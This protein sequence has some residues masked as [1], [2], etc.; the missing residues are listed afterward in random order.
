MVHP[1][2]ELILR[3]ASARFAEN[4]LHAT[5]MRDIASS[6]DLHLPSIY[7]FFANKEAL[8]GRCV[9]LA[10]QRT[11]EQLD[12]HLGPWPAGRA[13][14]TRLLLFVSGLCDLLA[15][16]PELRAFLLQRHRRGAPWLAGTPLQGVLERFAAL[17][18]QRRDTPRDPAHL[19]DRLVGLALGDA[20]GRATRAA[21]TD[22]A[23]AT[24]HSRFDPAALLELLSPGWAAANS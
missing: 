7:H 10:F 14:P 12:A 11:A 6:V 3:A 22:G 9:E 4:G 5:T 24:A 1:S 17:V 19:A 18:P 15:V 13:D 20:L 8:Y 21:A 16:D 2:K 23:E